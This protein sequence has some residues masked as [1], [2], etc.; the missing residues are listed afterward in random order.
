MKEHEIVAEVQKS[1]DIDSHEHAEQAVR[2]VLSVL[3]E[4][5]AGGEPKD[6][7]AQLPPALAEAIPTQGQGDQFGLDEF[8]S[9][10]AER[11]GRGCTPD[12]AREHTRATIAALKLAVTPGEFEEVADQLPKEYSELLT[13]N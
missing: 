3:G 2:A 10:V 11:E 6:L 1:T 8:Y 7:A 4:R 9:R 5:L 12:A 13:A